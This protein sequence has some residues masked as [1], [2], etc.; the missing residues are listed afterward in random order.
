MNTIRKMLD[1]LG[2]DWDSLGYVIKPQEIAY[3]GDE[4][5]EKHHQWLKDGK[6]LLDFEFDDS[7]GLRE[8]PEFIAQ[9]KD[10]FY[11]MSDYDGREELHAIKKDI[12][13]YQKNEIPHIGGGG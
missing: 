12:T 10:H 8:A 4:D 13:F 5:A 3:E 1:E 7:F 6:D 11:I 9:D 2:V